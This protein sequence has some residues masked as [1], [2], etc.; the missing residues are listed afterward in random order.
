ML[1][2]LASRALSNLDLVKAELNGYEDGQ[3]STFRSPLDERK[4]GIVY[5]TDPDPEWIIVD[6]QALLEH[7][8]EYPGNFET[9]LTIVGDEAEVLAVLHEH[10][11]HLVDEVTNI[12]EWIIKAALDASK[13][14][15]EA[16]APGIK[17]VKPGGVLTVTP[18]K[19]AGEAF[20][21]LI[22]A[23]LLTWDGQRAIGGVA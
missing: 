15:D 11:P 4:L 21:A 7:L 2:A 8:G 20:A 12:P 9:N 6:R 5:R 10:A 17:K 18:D 14:A 23:G 1:R 16:V 13:E 3:R 22:K 19:K